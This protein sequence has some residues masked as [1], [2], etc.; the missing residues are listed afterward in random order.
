MYPIQTLAD[1]D[2]WDVKGTDADVRTGY[3]NITLDHETSNRI[4][5]F[6]LAGTDVYP[7]IFGA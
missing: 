7:S 2:Y 3:A 1:S 4:N 5:E 6:E